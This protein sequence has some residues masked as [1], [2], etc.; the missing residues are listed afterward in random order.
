MLCFATADKYS[1]L[2]DHEFWNQ[3]LQFSIHGDDWNQT[4]QIKSTDLS[5]TMLKSRHNAIAGC[6]T[7]QLDNSDF[8]LFVFISSAS[9]Y[10]AKFIYVNDVFNPFPDLS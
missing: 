4:F 10:F 6:T 2:K 5:N 7:E 1:A 3:E 8:H 9:W